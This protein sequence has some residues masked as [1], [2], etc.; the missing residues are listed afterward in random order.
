MKG[1]WFFFWKHAGQGISATTYKFYKEED[2]Y[3]DQDNYMYEAEEWADKVNSDGTNRGWTYG[4]EEIKLPPKEWLDETILSHERRIKDSINQIE[5][6][7]SLPSIPC[8][9]PVED[10][11]NNYCKKCNKK[12]GD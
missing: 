8:I 5:F 7:K 3:V 4:V 1:K 6:L 9:H 12:I 11:V 10:I 2:L